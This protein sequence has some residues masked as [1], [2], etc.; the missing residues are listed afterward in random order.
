MLMAELLHTSGHPQEVTPHP[1]P[2]SNHR[3]AVPPQEALGPMLG[4]NSSPTLTDGSCKQAQ[5]SS[6]SVS[7]LLPTRRRQRKCFDAEQRDGDE[8]SA[9]GHC[10][11]WD[12]A[13]LSL[14]SQLLATGKT[15]SARSQP[16]SFLRHLKRRNALSM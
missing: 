3:G 10:C 11:P 14:S 8:G 13:L 15:Q 1:R 4:R 6:H 5:L 16:E 2:Q 12:F 9:P 7:Q